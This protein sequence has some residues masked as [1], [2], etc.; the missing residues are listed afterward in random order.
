M[1]DT[2]LKLFSNDLKKIINKLKNK[3]RGGKNGN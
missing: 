3:E 1:F 2:N